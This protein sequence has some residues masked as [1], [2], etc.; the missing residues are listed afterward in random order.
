MNIKKLEDTSLSTNDIL[1]IMNNNVNIITYPDLK[2]YKDINDLFSGS[3]NVI[4]YFEE[5][6]KGQNVIGH[7]EALKKVGN[8]IQFFDG[9]GI[10][11]DHCRKWLS[12]NK[13]IDLKEN[14]PELTR[15]IHKAIDDGYTVLWNHNRYQ[16]YEKD[17]STCGKWATSFL[18]HGNLNNTSFSDWVQSLI[19]KYRANTY[20]E[21]I[22]KWC[23]EN[24]GI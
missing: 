14:S 8:T 17:V 20:D 15:L 19:R 22:S 21:A 12:Q 5:D 11:P 6:K 9:Y 16:S 13:L 10:A 24:F 1:K 2:N 7:W 4:L 3:P 18:L 23:F